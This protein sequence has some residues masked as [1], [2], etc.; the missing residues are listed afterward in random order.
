ML[1]PWT[2]Q[3][4][5]AL[6]LSTGPPAAHLRPQPWRRCCWPK[7]PT[8]TP[9][10]R[11]AHSLSAQFWE[12]FW[13]KTFFYL[14]VLL[15]KNHRARFLI[16]V[17]T[18]PPGS[19]LRVT[20]NRTWMYKEAW[21]NTNTNVDRSEHTQSTEWFFKSIVGSNPVDIRVL[22]ISFAV[23][24]YYVPVL[25]LNLCTSFSLF[26]GIQGP[27]LFFIDMIDNDIWCKMKRECQNVPPSW[28]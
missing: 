7:M 16:S 2:S 6:R 13:T 17:G 22:H 15:N 28:L 18:G 3:T 26:F 1:L 8:W 27:R 19:R 10:M 21:R 11:M 4:T 23:Y 25:L 24:L 12:H 5:P 20:G 14:P 9:K